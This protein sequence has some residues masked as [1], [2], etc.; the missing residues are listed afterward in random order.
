MMG[1]RACGL[2]SRLGWASE[3][4]SVLPTWDRATSDRELQGFLDTPKPLMR[5]AELTDILRALPQLF[6]A[7]G[8]EPWALRKQIAASRIQFAAL[9]RSPRAKA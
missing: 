2:Q 8:P 7:L 5:I 6:W 9:P 4:R 3:F 1:V